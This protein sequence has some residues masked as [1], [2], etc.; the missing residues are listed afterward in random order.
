MTRLITGSQL[1]TEDATSSM[2]SSEDRRRTISRK[3]TVGHH[4]GYTTAEIDSSNKSKAIQSAD[5][6]KGLGRIDGG[7]LEAA[8]ETLENTDPLDQ[9]NLPIRLSTLSGLVYEMWRS[10]IGSSQ[11]HQQI[12][13]AAESAT[14]SASRAGVI[15][16]G[17]VR[18]LRTALTDLSSRVLTQA[19]VESIGSLLID[20]QFSPLAALADRED[21]EH[22]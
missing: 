13:A 21:V 7:L 9:A 15:G 1:S 19:N 2:Q 10:A 11:Y 14:I 18:A 6:P 16:E 3:D 8:L 5:V 20:E 4:G 12:L 17:Q 22:D